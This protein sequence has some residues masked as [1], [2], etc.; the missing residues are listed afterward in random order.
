MQK[1]TIR[2]ESPVTSYK[3]VKIGN[4]I[5]HVTSIFSGEKDLGK[6]LEELVLRRAM[7]ELTA[8]AAR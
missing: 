3:E 1:T 4:T 7:M 2:R 6:T 8:E 5:Y